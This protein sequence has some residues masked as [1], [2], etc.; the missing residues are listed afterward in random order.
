MRPVGRQAQKMLE[1]LV[2]GLH[3]PGDATAVG[4][5]PDGVAPARVEMI[6]DDHFC[7]YVS[8]KETVGEDEVILW[9]STAGEFCPYYLRTAGVEEY[10]ADFGPDG[11]PLRV[12]E[13]GQ[14]R[15]V[16]LCDGFLRST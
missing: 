15:L 12:D 10:F 8:R 13:P 4:S 6:A 16:A 1:R 2:D 9:R 14:A 5:G 11:M 3:E 7:L